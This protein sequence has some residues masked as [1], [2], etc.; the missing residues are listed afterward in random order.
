MYEKRAKKEFLDQKFLCFFVDFF[1]KIGE[2]TF[3][4]LTENLSAKKLAESGSINPPFN[5]KTR[6]FDKHPKMGPKTFCASP[7]F[8]AGRPSCCP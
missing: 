5:G 4:P 1:G 3:P 6:L 2:Y 8:Q 7:H